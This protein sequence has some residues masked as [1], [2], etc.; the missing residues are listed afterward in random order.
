[1]NLFMD[2]PA[3]INLTLEVLGKRNDG[4]HDLLSAIQTVN[5]FDTLTLAPAEGIELTCN[6]PALASADNLVVRAAIL[7]KAAT[8]YRGGAA[9]HLHKRIPTAAGLGGGSSDAAATLKGLAQLWDFTD[10]PYDGLV[11][12]CTQLG[13]DVPF[14]LRG[15][16]SMVEARGDIVIPLPP[17]RPTHFVL[18]HPAIDIAN[19][20]AKMYGSLSPENYT[21]GEV[22]ERL[23]G[24]LRESGRLCNSLLFNVFDTVAASVLPGIEDEIERFAWIAGRPVVLS[25]AGPTL[26]CLASDRDDSER[27]RSN[28]ASSGFEAYSCQSWT[29]T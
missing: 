18:V 16:T 23:I 29:P 13:M 24:L 26:Y 12:I 19:K 21:T 17:L 7:F 22:T 4:Y 11:E 9:I 25:G 10:F 27:L 20:T 8:G 14:F 6:I 1:M 5:L 2:A 15:G 28:L 3:K